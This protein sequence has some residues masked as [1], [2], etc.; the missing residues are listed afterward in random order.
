M[1]APIL[2]LNVIGPCDMNEG[3]KYFFLILKINSKIESFAEFEDLVF[4]ITVAADEES[5]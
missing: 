1:A 2:I 4:S 3:I 5:G